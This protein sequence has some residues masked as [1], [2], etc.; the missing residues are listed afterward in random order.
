MTDQPEPFRTHAEGY[1]VFCEIVARREPA[2]VRYEDD[3]VLVFDNILHWFPLMLL[4]VPKPHLKQAELWSDPTWSARVCQVGTQV[5]AQ[6]SPGGFRFVANF[7]WN[8]IQTQ[9]HGHLHVLGGTHLG[10]YG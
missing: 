2:K 6:L 3:H 5:G 9:D 4:V 1:C 7:G 10:H 8:A